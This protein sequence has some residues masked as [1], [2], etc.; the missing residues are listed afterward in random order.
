MIGAQHDGGGGAP[1]ASAGTARRRWSRARLGATCTGALAVAVAGGAWARHAPARE[2]RAQP[3]ATQVVRAGVAALE[4]PRAW[5]TVAPHGEG[6]GSTAVLA[7]SAGSPARMIVTIAPPVDRSLVPRALRELVR[8]LGD[9]PRATL[10][11][12]H[13]GWRYA[14]PA[15][16]GSD[17]TISVTVLPSAVG[18]LGIACVPASSSPDCAASVASVSMGGAA[19]FLPSHDLALRLRLPRVLAALDRER[20][21]S[22]ARLRQAGSAGAQ[23][24]L[25][26]RLARAHLAAADSLRPVAGGADAA[27]VDRLSDTAGAYFALGRAASGSSPSRFRAARQDVHVA[28]ARLAPV[29]DG[30]VQRDGLH[31]AAAPATRLPARPSAATTPD[32][33]SAPLLIVALVGLLVF[34]LGVLGVRAP[35]AFA[36]RT[37]R[38]QRVR[39]T[40]RDGSPGSR[41]PADS[42][43]PPPANGLERPAAPFTRWDEPPEPAPMAS[44]EPSAAVEEAT[45]AA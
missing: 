35:L 27:L 9:G 38:R 40:V 19:A 31:A 32:S 4:V 18:V 23:T 3:P 22:R 36:A 43:A 14:G 5:R 39:R 2:Q 17:E 34:A 45:A 12:G 10:V 37:R 26:R 1:R 8:D 24:R 7:P 41:P 20:V 13:R 16:R 25:A 29:V 6:A 42:G 28:E 15:A 33:S 21:H 11:A 44:P 30:L